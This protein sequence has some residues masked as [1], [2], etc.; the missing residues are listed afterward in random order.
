[1]IDPSILLETTES[2][3]LISSPA[4]Q[5]EELIYK[6]QIGAYSKA[7]P[8]YVEKMFKKLSFI[9]KN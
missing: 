8:P 1:M 2:S 4:K 9:T 6:V 7:P 3:D 5:K